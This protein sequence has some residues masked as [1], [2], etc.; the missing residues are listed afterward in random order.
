M[1]KVSILLLILGALAG[2]SVFAGEEGVVDKA[3]KGIKRGADA[4]AR[5][6]EKAVHATENGVSK[7]AQAT[8]RFFKKADERVFKKADAWIGENVNK[9]GGGS[10]GGQKSP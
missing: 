1:K 4:A 8:E 7:G 9:K 5:G 10:S 6:A 3:G 2:Q